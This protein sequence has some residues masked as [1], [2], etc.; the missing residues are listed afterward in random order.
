VEWPVVENCYNDFDP[1]FR[2]WFANTATGP[3]DVIIIIDTS[4]SMQ[5]AG[6]ITLAKNAAKKILDTLTD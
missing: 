5:T 2:P 6:R 1:R 4:G 3:K